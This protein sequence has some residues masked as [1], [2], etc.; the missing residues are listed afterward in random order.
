MAGG[1]HIIIKRVSQIEELD[2]SDREELSQI[3]IRNADGCS[4][5]DAIRV[6]RILWR[7]LRA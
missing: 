3:A 5:A 4:L 7:Y 6:V 1:G 2:Y